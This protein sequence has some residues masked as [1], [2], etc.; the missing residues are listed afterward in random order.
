MS[1]Y[2]ERV[3]TYDIDFSHYEVKKDN[4]LNQK[5]AS[6]DD[7][8][9]IIQRECV[10]GHL[11]SAHGPMEMY[12]VDIDHQGEMEKRIHKAFC[13]GGYKG[14]VFY[15][16]VNLS[17]PMADFWNSIEQEKV[18]TPWHHSGFGVVQY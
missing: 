18:M 6:P 9:L 11:K 7:C 2:A 4:I 10:D 8:L 16:D 13:D 17:E 14:L 1:L 3:W 5:L 15:D 12:F